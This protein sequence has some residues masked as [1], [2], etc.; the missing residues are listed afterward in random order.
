MVASTLI[1]AASYPMY[2]AL[3]HKFSTVGLAMASDLGIAANCLALALLLHR[4]K[5]VSFIQLQWRE[6][7]KAAVTAVGAGLL[8]YNGARHDGE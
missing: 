4:R 6:I 7:G 2:A 5:L 3:F 8:S 1:T